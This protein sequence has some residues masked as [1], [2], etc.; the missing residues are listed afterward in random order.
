MADDDNVPGCGGPAEPLM[1]AAL[2]RALTR[3]ADDDRPPATWLD[4]IIRA[5]LDKAGAGDLAA[6]REIYDRADGKPSA[7][8]AGEQRPASRIVHWMD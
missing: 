2:L 8:A 4:R 1:R 5:H 3:P 6:I 7:A